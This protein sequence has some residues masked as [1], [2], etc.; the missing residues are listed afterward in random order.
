MHRADPAPRSAPAIALSVLLSALLLAGA[1]GAQS[2]PY[3]GGAAG[4]HY[5]QF[6]FGAYRGDFA[7]AG[8]PLDGPIVPD[9]LDQAVGGL[10]TSANDTTTAFWYAAVAQA[11]S[12][13]DLAVLWVRRPGGGLS[14][15]D[16]PID[17]IGR[18]VLFGY[19]DG[20]SD[21]TPPA[22]PT[23]F[24]PAAWLDGLVCEHLFLALSGSVHVGSVSALGWS[25]TFS[26]LAADPA[27]LMI[28]ISG[29]YFALNGLDVAVEQ[30][31][32]GG[33]KATF[34]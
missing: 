21:F 28:S 2:W 17:A 8:L 5:Q 23:N 34:R 32:W 25:G 4:F 3:V 26:G 7:A 27:P 1:A 20:I 14:P 13:V 15:G 33:L 31:S 29:G 24:D 9:D 22:D 19:I 30:E 12:T 6:P 10:Y 18:T 16:Y 11:D